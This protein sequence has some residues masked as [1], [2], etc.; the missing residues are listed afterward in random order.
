MTAR[1][2]Q[3]GKEIADKVAPTEEGSVNERLPTHL[4]ATN[5]FPS[6]MNN[7]YSSLEYQLLVRDVLEGTDEIERLLGSCFGQYYRLSVRK[8]TFSTEVLDDEHDS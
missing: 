6:K 2:K 5:R 8:C 3:A 1:R 4:C 7:Y